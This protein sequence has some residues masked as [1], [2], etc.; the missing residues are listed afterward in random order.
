MQ[1][2][3]SLNLQILVWKTCFT[4]KKKRKKRK[5]RWEKLDANVGKNKWI[6]SGDMRLACTSRQRVFEAKAFNFQLDILKGN[7]SVISG[8]WW[9]W[10]SAINTAVSPTEKK[11]KTPLVLKAE[12]LLEIVGEEWEPDAASISALVPPAGRAWRECAGPLSCVKMI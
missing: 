4:L 11:K 7:H 8:L 6:K 3:A 5:A 10:S 12:K 9:L 1:H 2:L